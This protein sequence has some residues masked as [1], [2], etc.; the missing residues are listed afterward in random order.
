MV[1]S[2]DD[3]VE[4]K[5]GLVG[6]VIN[7]DNVGR[8]SGEVVLKVLGEPEPVTVPTDCIKGRFP[9]IQKH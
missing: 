6:M 5:D 3:W 4:T 9:G 8:A 7:V 2:V 1:L